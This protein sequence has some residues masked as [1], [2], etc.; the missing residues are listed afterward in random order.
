MVKAGHILPG[1]RVVPTRGPGERYGM[2]RVVKGHH[3][4]RVPIEPLGVEVFGVDT[5]QVQQER[6]AGRVQKEIGV[7]NGCNMRTVCSEQREVPL[8]RY[9]FEAASALLHFVNEPQPIRSICRC[10]GVF[11]PRR[12]TICVRGISI[13][14]CI[15]HISV[16]NA[17]FRGVIRTPLY[18][19]D[20]RPFLY[21]SPVRPDALR[22]VVQPPCAFGLGDR[23]EDVHVAFVHTVSIV[24]GAV[25]PQTQ[26]SPIGSFLRRR[27]ELQQLGL[28]CHVKDRVL[29]MEISDVG[30]FGRSQ[31]ADHYIVFVVESV[32]NL[33]VRLRGEIDDLGL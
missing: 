3:V 27:R 1:A 15:D 10:I 30:Y 33:A 8:P 17:G 28:G 6:Q 9:G 12:R 26:P 4:P 16:M 23:I 14:N 25:G 32:H 11:F 22:V 5:L 20:R 2:A 13:G 7:V 19:F 18:K 24:Q 29:A 21:V 31:L